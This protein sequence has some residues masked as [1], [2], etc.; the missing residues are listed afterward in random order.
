MAV[1]ESVLDSID[2]P[3]GGSNTPSTPTN[4]IATVAS[5]SQINL[6]WDA[7]SGATSYYVYG[8]TSSSGTYTNIATV[9]TSSYTNTGLWAGTTYYYKVQAVNSAGSSS[10]STITYGTTTASN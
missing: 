8:A 2:A 1:P 4:L 6:S 9:T 5:P 7:I 10:Y 3:T